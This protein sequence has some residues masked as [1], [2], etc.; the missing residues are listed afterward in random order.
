LEDRQLLAVQAFAP[1]QIIVGFDGDIVAEFRTEGPGQALQSA[2]ARYG[3]LGLQNGE[4]LL[5]RPAGA[6]GGERLATLWKLPPG[7]DVLEVAAALS[8]MA[9]VAYAEP[10][11]LLSTAATQVFPNDPKF[12]SLWGMHNTGAGGGTADADI[13]APEAWAVHSGSGNVVVAVIDTGVNYNHADLKANSWTNPF[14]IAGNGIDD[15]GNGYAD[16]IK[17]YDFVNNDANPIDDNGHG[18]HVSG[19]IGA[20][21]NNG[22]GVVGVDQ[23]VKIMGLKFLD[24]GGGGTTENA[25]RAVQYATDMRNRGVNVVLTS[26]SWGGGAFSQALYDAID[27]SGDAGMLFVAAAGNNGGSSASYPALY[28]LDNII[29][30][31]ATDRNDQLASFSN[32][33]TGVDIAAPGVAVYSTY[34]NTYK[35][36]D[37]TSMATPHVSGAAALVADYLKTETGALPSYQDLRD[38]ILNSGD[39]IPAAQSTVA[40]G[41]RLNAHS[42]LL[43]AD[44]LA[45]NAVGLAVADATV[46]EG[47]AGTTSVTI[48]VTRSGRTDTTTTVNWATAEASAVAGSDFASASGQLVFAPGETTGLFQVTVLGDTVMEPEESFKVT[49]SGAS[50]SDSSI[51]AVLLRS[52]SAATIVND[53]FGLVSHWTADA[54][55]ADT[56]GTNN[57]TLVSGATYAAGQVGQAF[58]F[59]GVDDRVIVADSENLKLTRSL[60]IEGWVRVDAISS[61]RNGQILFR[62]DDRGGLDPYALSVNTNGSLRFLV[63]PESNSGTSI[64]TPAPVGEFFHVAA[65]LDDASGA[66]RLYVNGGLA[67]ET[68]TAARPFRDLD[69]TRNPGIG[70][71]NH[72]GYPATPHNFP[73]DGL[74]DE[75]KVYNYALDAADV[76]EHFNADR[77]RLPE[78]S[79]SI[80]DVTANEREDSSAEFTV[81]LSKPWGAPVSVNFSTVDGSATAATGDYTPTSDIITFAPGE[82]K[83]TIAI[84]IFDNPGPDAAEETFSVLLSSASGA[85]IADNAG[86]AT[87]LQ[88][89][90]TVTYANTSPKA[91]RDAATTTSTITV[92]DGITILDLN[93]QLNITHTWDAD[94][95]VSLIGPDGTRVQLFRGL[96]GSGDN[97]TG[98]ILDDEAALSI[99]NGTAPFSG[100]YRPQGLLSTFDGK[101]AAG[102]WT[103]EIIDEFRQDKGTLNAWSLDFSRAAPAQSSMASNSTAIDSTTE[104]GNRITALDAVAIDELLTDLDSGWTRKSRVCLPV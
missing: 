94:L 80:G 43:Y 52:Q 70:I 84:P 36:L 40:T 45:G 18:T 9:G 37:G 29:S 12:S 54:T 79:I 63:T 38:A 20:T 47:D 92:P 23:N 10:N 91:I 17:G 25:I 64:G 89:I 11:Y 77:G 103:L 58:S 85:T 68:I 83:R 27:A 100:S 56:A 48:T 13:D 86:V 101:S 44:A 39:K 61:T 99:T 102:V 69:P 8:G 14:E 3:G 53:D 46:T 90:D 71:G 15:D 104:N 87:I 60:T 55:A 16:D 65:T 51:S 42:A 24:A 28:N 7:K 22:T 57:G 5:H 93:V 6:H 88:G 26:N 66:I 31:A 78:P 97:F 73:F 59:D 98:T 32:R 96:G 81:S 62:G 2:A 30:V 34:N 21:G 49:L 41:S 1:G 50:N 74:I 72:G 35:S 67:S 76:L 4:A 19:T 75:L 95:F 33:G 82:T